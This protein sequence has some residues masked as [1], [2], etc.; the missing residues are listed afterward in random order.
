MLVEVKVLDRGSFP[1]PPTLLMKLTK[2]TNLTCD[3]PRRVGTVRGKFSHLAFADP[4]HGA[5]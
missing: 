2:L 4:Y 3:P 1:T 5:G